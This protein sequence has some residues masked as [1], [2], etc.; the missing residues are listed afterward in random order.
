MGK[1]SHLMQAGWIIGTFVWWALIKTLKQI[2]FLNYINPR[3][4]KE[5]IK[6]VCNWWCSSLFLCL[7]ESLPQSDSHNHSLALPPLPCTIGTVLFTMES[8][9]NRDFRDLRATTHWDAVI[10]DISKMW[11]NIKWD[12][13]DQETT[14]CGHGTCWGYGIPLPKTTMK[15]TNLH[16]FYIN[17]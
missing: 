17:F 11:Q 1:K 13:H 4:S 15:A 6:L 12:C 2:R 14:R 10:L 3:S 7:S 16:L 9:V 5:N 8:T